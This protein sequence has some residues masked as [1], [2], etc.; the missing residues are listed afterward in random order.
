[1]K[2]P[3][4]GSENIKRAGKYKGK[5]KTS[6]GYR[7]KCCGKYFVERD[8][9]ERKHYPKEVIVRALHLYI[10]GLSL[11][12]IRDFLWQ[13]FGYSPSDSTI[14]DWVRCYSKL[15]RRLQRKLRPKLRGR[16]HVDEVFVKVGGERRPVIHAVDS[17][18]GYELEAMLAKRRDLPTY[19][20]FFKRLKRRLGRQIRGVFRR[21]RHKPPKRRKL[22]TFVSDR[23]GPIRRAFNRYF[24]RIAKLVF[25]VPIAC[26]RFGLR[27]NNNPVERRNGDIKQRYKVMRCFKSFRMAQAFVCLYT[28]VINFVRHGKRES[29]AHRVGV[30]PGL[31]RNRLASLIS[32]AATH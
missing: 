6:Q 1:V 14:L 3:K 4:C 30:W 12:K 7:C 9:F 26:K 22:V 8:G 31:G 27:F 28:V 5:Y 32:L 24:Y 29:P 16:A 18:T 19:D 13:H 2:C 15:L 21:E 23:W 20:R 11:S 25:G 10:E 17:G